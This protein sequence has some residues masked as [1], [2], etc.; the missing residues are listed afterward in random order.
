MPEWLNWEWDYDYERR[1]L[2]AIGPDGTEGYVIAHFVSHPDPGVL[3]CMKTSEFREMMIT[4]HTPA[5]GERH[6]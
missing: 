1:Q 6:G 2:H 3:A 4:A 5:K